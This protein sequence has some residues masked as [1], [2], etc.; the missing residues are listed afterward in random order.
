MCPHG[1]SC[2]GVLCTALPGR[3][4]PSTRS[5]WMTG[6]CRWTEGNSLRT[7]GY[8][9]ISLISHQHIK[10]DINTG[11]APNT[12]KTPLLNR[13]I[14]LFFKS[15]CP[16]S[17]SLS[18]SQV[19]QAAKARPM[20]LKLLVL[21]LQPFVVASILP[22]PQE[23]LLWNG[24]C[25]PERWPG[26]NLSQR[27]VVV[28]SYLSEEDK[29]PVI[30]ISNG[31]QLFVDSF[32]VDT[33]RS[34]NMH[35]AYHSA[36]YFNGQNQNPNPVLFAS[37]PWEVDKA[38]MAGGYGGFASPF[39]GGSW[40]NP[41]QNRYELFYR[42]GSWFCVA[43]SNDTITWTKPKLPFQQHTKACNDQLCNIIVPNY[44]DGATVWLDLDAKNASRRY[45]FASGQ[46]IFCIVCCSI[47]IPF[48]FA[49][50]FFVRAVS[51]I[52]IR[53][54]IMIHTSHLASPYRWQRVHYLDLRRRY[55]IPQREC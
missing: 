8:L 1:G 15:S 10:Q 47:S 53:T 29:P 35:T 27:Q 41:S 26:Q 9:C 11:G 20:V 50:V 36:N 19:L 12:G 5:S 42:C 52:M 45:I 21:F 38:G 55:A 54:C 2:G 7:P 37:E 17:L 28:P 33:N 25:R 18:L 43:W 40:W 24:L 22:C 31:R 16:L 39:S 30:N 51:Y 49:F 44:Y 23:R 48:C 46:S 32:L 4:L 6:N 3:G 13:S 14:Y 34:K